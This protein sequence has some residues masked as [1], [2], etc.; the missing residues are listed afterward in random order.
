[1]TAKFSV[2]IEPAGALSVQFDHYDGVGASDKT[3]PDGLFVF[4][5][6]QH[7]HRPHHPRLD[8]PYTSGTRYGGAWQKFDPTAG[9]D[10]SGQHR[11]LTFVGEETAKTAEYINRTDVIK[12]GNINSTVQFRVTQPPAMSMT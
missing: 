9:P 11:E 10:N 1:M 2:H 12:A 4:L 7:R 6:E 8:S 5:V 3:S